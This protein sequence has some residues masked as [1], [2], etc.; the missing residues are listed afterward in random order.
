MQPDD[1]NLQWITHQAMT[2][3]PRLIVTG[4]VH[5]IET[6]GRVAIERVLDDLA[7][8]R[9]VLRRGRLT[10]VPVCNPLALARGTREGEGDLNRKLR[11]RDTP[12][13]A[14]ER[15]ANVLCPLLLEHDVLLDLHSFQ[16]A[17][18][19]FVVM[20]PPAPFERADDEAALAC[21][22]GVAHAVEGR[23]IA[24]A[25]P[26]PGPEGASTAIFMRAH[27]RYGVTLECGQHA[28]PEA[29]AR[30]YRAIVATLAHLGMIDAPRPPAAAMRAV[31]FDVNVPRRAEG[32]RFARTWRS[33]DAVTAGEL[34]GTFA[35]G[36]PLHAPH[37]GFLVFPD[38][39][40]KPGAEWVNIG[41]AGSRAGDTADCV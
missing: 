40:A 12:Q 34:I 33:F 28:D 10:L 16:S 14:E 6:C 4:V 17:G 31:A 27:G 19:P 39:L 8:R 13:T 11:L 9:I 26:Q 2:D 41:R 22:L 25:R 1:I 38:P 20:G 7:T 3:G 32:D 21:R 37:D 30:G 18:P 36:Q 29:P 5:G 23:P 15:I 35:D 24:T